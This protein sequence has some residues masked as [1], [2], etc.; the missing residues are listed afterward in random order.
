[1]QRISRRLIR[2]TTVIIS[3]AF[4]IS[5]LLGIIS[6]LT[7]IGEIPKELP[8]SFG[9]FSSNI[10]IGIFGT[11]GSIIVTISA[12]S[13]FIILGF[14]INVKILGERITNFSQNLMSKLSSFKKSEAISADKEDETED[15]SDI[16]QNEVPQNS[17]D[18]EPARIM[19]R[20]IEEGQVDVTRD[21]LKAY[22][23]T[24]KSDTRQDAPSNKRDIEIKTYKESETVREESSDEQKNEIDE[25]DEINDS[26]TDS[27]VKDH[28]EA[29][30]ISESQ[31]N[32]TEAK[33]DGESKKLVVTVTEPVVEEEEFTPVN[34]LS[35]SIHDRDIKYI[36]PKI[37][38]LIDDEDKYTVNEDELKL[39][40]RILQEKLETFKIFIEN[41]SV[42]PGPVVTQYEFIPAAGI[43]I[44]KIEALADDIAMALKARGI[45]IIAP[46]PGKGT[47]GIE[48]PNQQPAVVRFSSCLKSSK[49]QNNNHRL[50]I[51]L[52]KTISGEV[53]IAD[54]AK[55]PHLLIAGATGTGK[56]VGINTIINSLLFKMHPKYLKFVIIDPKKVE[57]TQ[58]SRL[59]N[60]FLA[61]SP[62]IESSII[63]DPQD[64]VVV[65]N[66]LCAEMDLRYEILAQ[67]GQRNIF[68]YNKKVREGK[69][70]DD[71]ELI[72]K[73]MPYIVTIID[74][75]ADLMLTAAKEVETPIIRLA[76]L[77][78]AVGIHLVLATQRPSVDVITGII[79]ANFPARI[80]Y[81]VASKIDS[82]TILDVMGAEKLLGNGDLLFQYGGSSSPLRI[83]NSF[84]SVDEVEDIC[85]HIGNQEGYSRAY[86]LP[87]LN[88]GKA[89][90]G[91]LAKEDR[92]V[93]FD[94]AARMVVA[95]QIASV[96]L[97]QRR[98][99]V[100]YARAGRIIDE[101]EATG[102][103]S[104]FDGS[105]A[106]SVLIESESDLE[107][108]L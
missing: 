103:I 70:K 93:L 75:L 32:I 23:K 94:E 17:E 9:Y 95:L 74:E 13:L 36:P 101:L 1:M 15:D 66:A 22:I 58:Y 2:F 63:T 39:N 47:V 50:P 29:E 26:S 34:P 81:L 96:S 107:L 108:L 104:G 98:L 71:E 88:D 7:W 90:A 80:S 3:L 56:S 85:S 78:R 28:D 51:A 72:H 5:S 35:T 83:Q 84:I 87:A 59:E 79:K 16:T 12:I 91:G 77:A 54:L 99:K 19:K 45:R 73:E 6:H 61:V 18:D 100:G 38:L 21:P 24:V 60:H 68:D 4:L 44:S 33:N 97:L 8:G 57:L 49:F 62:D 46:I 65:L 82:R 40:A 48:I 20:N 11:I 67:A 25:I 10:L 105:K 37:D 102:I 89:G 106:R 31:E 53:Y 92:D 52:G 41:L 42:T 86:T 14:R 55:M 30:D 43:K 27:A 76:Q 64:A 69:L